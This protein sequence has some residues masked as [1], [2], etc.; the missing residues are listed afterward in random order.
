MTKEHQISKYYNKFKRSP[1]QVKATVW[2]LLCSFLQK[3]ISTLTTP[4]FTR[5]LSTTEFGQYNTFNS[6]LGI[7]QVVLTLNIVSGVLTQELVKNEKERD[8]FSSSMQGLTI[9]LCFLGTVVYLLFRHQINILLGLSSIQMMAMFLMIWATTAFGIWSV[10]QRV[11][12]SY[13]KLVIIT[14]IVSLAKPILSIV[15]IL[16]YNDKVTARILGLMIAEIIGYSGVALYQLFKGKK[17]FS[18]DFWKYA[19]MLNVPLIPHALSQTI[20]INADRIMIEKFIGNSEEGIYSLA[21][22]ISQI[23]IIFNQSLGQTLAPWTYE[24]I[25]AH[26]VGEIKSVAYSTMIA[27][28]VVNLLMMLF[29]PEIL[30]VFAPSTYH[31]AVMVIPPIAMA[32]FFMYLYDWFARFEYYFEKS[33]W[34]MVA[35]VTGAVLNIVL[36]FLLIPLW[37]YSAAAYTTLICYIVYSFMHY[38]F[39]KK[40]C[41]KE[42]PKEEVYNT[43]FILGI[44][45]CFC[46]LGFIVL[47]TYNSILVRYTLIVCS[48]I[49][50]FFLRKRIMKLINEI[51]KLRKNKAERVE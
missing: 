20:L 39:M 50:L 7:I 32:T 12:Y 9:T 35:S 23:M 41:K 36:N 5:L 51:I 17:F 37:G 42:F 22:S 28:G 30:F 46:V 44:S 49:V 3:G 16:N 27:I 1:V 33:I 26:R 34:I 40:I 4:I 2:F 13:K 25:K 38:I 15:L 6:W 11:T 19:I 43:K 21:Y 10:Y 48:L 47:F 18:K 31:E 45:I 29:A 24:K 8:E 14:L